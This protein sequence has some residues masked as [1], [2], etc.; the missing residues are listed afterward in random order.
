MFNIKSK[1]RPKWYNFRWRLS[2]LFVKIAT[3]IYPEN[4]E[5]IAFFMKLIQDEM[6]YGKSV[7]R[8]EPGEFEKAT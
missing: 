1:E 8:V 3:K 6:I 4:P 7:I 2:N 5:V